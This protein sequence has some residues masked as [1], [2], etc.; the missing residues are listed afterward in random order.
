MILTNAQIAAARDVCDASPLSETHPATPA[1]VDA[2]GAHTFFLH[3]DGLSVFLDPSEM[4]LSADD[5][6]MVRIA[7]WTDERRNQLAQ[8]EPV[9]LDVSL[10]AD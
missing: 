8:I 3:E 6:T 10:P 9:V 4:D 5:P 1:L 2:F 7:V